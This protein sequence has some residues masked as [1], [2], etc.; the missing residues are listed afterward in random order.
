MPERYIL[1]ARRGIYYLLE[2]YILFARKV[3]TFLLKAPYV[4][5]GAKPFSPAYVR[6]FGEWP[7]IRYLCLGKPQTWGHLYP[8]RIDANRYLYECHGASV[9]RFA[10]VEILRYEIPGFEALPLERKLFVYH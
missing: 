4:V 2:G 1:F 6:K 10:D 5:R 9:T 8:L 7:L 3:Y